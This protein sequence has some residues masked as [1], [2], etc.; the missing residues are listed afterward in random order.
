MRGTVPIVADLP[1]TGNVEGD[2]WIV[3][4]VAGD[5]ERTNVL[6]VWDEDTSAWLD[7]GGIA[8]PPG[9]PGATGSPGEPGDSGDPGEQGPRGTGWFV[10]TGAPPAEIAGSQPGDLYLDMATGDV[11]ALGEA[12]A[13]IPIGDLPALG[14]ALEGG[15]YGGLYSLNGDGV[16]THALI[17]SPKATG[18]NSTLAWKNASTAGSG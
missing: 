12:P 3:E 17:V 9:S 4:T 13:G 18:F 7:L 2:G 15:F 5:P 6:F 1:A 10:G 8:G 14:G 11:Y 16:A